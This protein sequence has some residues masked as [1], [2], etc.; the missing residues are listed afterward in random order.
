MPANTLPPITEVAFQ[1]QVIQLA[2]LLGWMVYHTLDSRG[3]SAGFPDLVLVRERDRRL[4]FA[5]L[6][7][8]IGRVRKEQSEWLAALGAVRSVAVEVYLWRPADLDEIAGVLR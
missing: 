7:T 6:K 2:R 4:I 1:R 3:S 8:D 5:E